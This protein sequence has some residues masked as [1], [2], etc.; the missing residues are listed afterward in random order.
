MFILINEKIEIPDKLFFLLNTKNII[1]KSE[2]LEISQ[3][4][5]P[6]INKSY[7]LICKAINLHKNLKLQNLKFRNDPI[8]ISSYFI[9]Q[10]LV[11]SKY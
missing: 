8:L 10:M 2:G 11:S 7:L 5:H 3:S 4:N 1:S 9:K 6:D